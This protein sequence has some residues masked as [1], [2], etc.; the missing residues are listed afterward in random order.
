V[1]D[2]LVALNQ[3]K[4]QFETARTQ[5]RNLQSF[6]RDAQLRA[7]A[8]QRDVAQARQ[9]A[10]ETQLGYSRLVSPIDGVVS[11]L[12]F[13]PGESAPPGTAVVT[14]MDLSEVIAK[15]HVSQV[16]AGTLAV[17]NDAN[18]IGPDGITVPGKVTQI[19]PALDAGSSTVEVW[20]LARNPDSALRAG[21]TVRVEL[22]A[23]T[24]TDALVIPESAVLTASTGSTYT[25]VVAD[26]NKPHLRKVTIGV[27]DSGRAQVTDGLAG[28]QRVAT[29][30][31]YEI[32]T[33]DEDVRDRTTVKVAPPKEE[34][35]EP[36]EN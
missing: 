5:L 4:T 16:D 3:A 19:S 6:A 2:A 7:A 29:A 30:G 22:V 32:F 31:A 8:A 25:I 1:N 9:A 26:D 18:L 20:V 36:D 21:A 14:V 28:G 35:E 15:A 23:R 12:P 13:Y 24:V 33:L 10:A 11:D 27:R 34:E 17:G